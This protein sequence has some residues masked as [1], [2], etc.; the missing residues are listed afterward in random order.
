MR[1]CLSSRS[2]VSTAMREAVPPPA[3]PPIPS[4][5]TN[6]L[7]SSSMR[8]LSS[9]WSRFLPTS[10]SPAETIFNRTGVGS[11]GDT[12][13]ADGTGAAPRRARRVRVRVQSRSGHPSR[14]RDRPD[15][16]GA[17][18][19]ARAA[20]TSASAAAS[21]SAVTTAPDSIR[22]SSRV[23]GVPSASGTHAGPGPPAGG[24]LLHHQVGIGVRRHLRQMGDA[25]HLTPGG[26]APAPCGRPRRPP[27]R[28]PR[29]RPR[30]AP[31]CWP[32]PGRPAPSRSA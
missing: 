3:C 21:A 22:A 32:P 15:G 5:T 17:G 7:R 27:R 10:V 9:L 18:S 2:M 29:R 25:E 20:R 28:S 8:K 26:H 14:A 1:T 12:L 23:R 19:T 31:R 30:R 11:G 6:S 16:R 4:A 24:R 13:T